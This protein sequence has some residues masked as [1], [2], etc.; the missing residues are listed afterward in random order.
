MPKVAKIR[1]SENGSIA[2]IM[3]TNGQILTQQQ[4]VRKADQGLIGNVHVV[5]PKYDKP[6]IRTNPN[7]SEKDNLDEKPTF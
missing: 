2:K 1:R 4:A 7:S 6:F 5:Q 3:L